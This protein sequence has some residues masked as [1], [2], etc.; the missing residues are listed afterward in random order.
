MKSPWDFYRKAGEQRGKLSFSRWFFFIF[1]MK[2]Y[3]ADSLPHSAENMR[4]M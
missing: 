2:V 1:S 4:V 3:H